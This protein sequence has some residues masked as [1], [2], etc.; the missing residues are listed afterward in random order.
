MD[1]ILA[2]IEIGAK[3]SL[4]VGTLARQTLIDAGAN[5]LGSEGYF[6]FEVCEMPL[7]SGITVLGKAASFEA[8]I[9][10]ADILFQPMQVAHA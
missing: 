8:A 2:T 9:R 5:H 3:S 6:I 4:C 10:L 7:A 1:E